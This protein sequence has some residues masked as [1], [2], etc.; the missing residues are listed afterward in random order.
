MAVAL[1]AVAGLLLSSAQTL[2]ND[3]NLDA[4]RIALM[5]LRPR[6]VGYSPE[7]AQRFLRD[8]IAALEA[9]PGV[10]SVSLH[11]VA[12]VRSSEERDVSL[13]ASVNGAQTATARQT[14]RVR[15]NKLGP[16]TF[17]TLGIPM[18]RGREFDDREAGD[19]RVLARLGG[20]DGNSAAS[21]NLGLAVINETLARSLWAGNDAL[22]ASFVMDQRTYQ[23]IGIAADILLNDR[24]SS[25]RPY[26]YVPAQAEP[27]RIDARLTIRVKGDP[28]A[29]LPRLVREVNRV[30]PAV[31]VAE[32]ITLTFQLAHGELKAARMT[33]T[34]LTYAAGLA[35]L[36][37]GLGVY[38]TLAFSVSRRTKEFGIRQAI[39][40]TP[41]GI[42]AMILTE[43]LATIALGA[44]AGIGF[45]ILGTRL[46]RHLLYR[47]SAADPVFYV[48]AAALVIAVALFA[49]SIPA[50]R[51]TRIEPL[52][53]LRDE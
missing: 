16:R 44:A 9:S 32:T 53:A 20:T 11:D 52:R 49:C 27:D 41:R 15:F 24:D 43:G 4:N 14:M 45:A 19:P 31:P 3:I 34:F 28:G 23:V 37:C 42:L 25:P 38:G 17:A 30:D 50:L 2:T 6:L 26:V 46:V 10:E 47:T 48:C 18:V 51:A 35:V 22:G 8:A 40:A 29:M 13:P 7:K 36:L 39:G 5:R 12:A 1:G 33:A 21:G